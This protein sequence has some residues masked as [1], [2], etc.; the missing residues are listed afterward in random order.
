VAGGGARALE[1]RVSLA[2]SAVVSRTRRRSS[3]RPCRAPAGRRSSTRPATRPDR[4]HSRRRVRSIDE[5]RSPRYLRDR[6]QSPDHLC[7][8]Q[9]GSVSAP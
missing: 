1:G 9:P 7:A 4:T 6:S 8:D 5:H 3:P 2:S